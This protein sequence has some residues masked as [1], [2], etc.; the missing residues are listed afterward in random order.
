MWVPGRRREGGERGGER[1]DE[2]WGGGDCERKRLAGVQGEGKGRGRERPECERTENVFSF[3]P[4]LYLRT[5][6]KYGLSMN[7]PNV[8]IFS[9]YK[10][11]P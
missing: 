8:P 11:T 2:R 3:V 10:K 6:K 9:E 1:R 5:R 4:R 7:V